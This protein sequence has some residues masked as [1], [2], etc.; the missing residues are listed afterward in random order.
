MLDLNRAPARYL[1]RLSRQTGLAPNDWDRLAVEPA[2]V[3][4]ERWFVLVTAV[5]PA[6][7]MP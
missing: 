6:G 4:D 2:F 5:R 3:C 7:P 1:E